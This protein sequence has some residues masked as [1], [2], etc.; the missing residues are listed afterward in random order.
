MRTHH[1]QG[2]TGCE[3]EAEFTPDFGLSVVMSARQTVADRM[4]SSIESIATSTAGSQAIRLKTGGLDYG[5]VHIVKP[6]VEFPGVERLNDKAGGHG[7]FLDCPSTRT[8]SRSRFG[9]HW[10]T[11]LFLLGLSSLGECKA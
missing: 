6:F 4:P 5:L 8:S 2:P 10:T 3:G 11:S 9:S 7:S 1:H